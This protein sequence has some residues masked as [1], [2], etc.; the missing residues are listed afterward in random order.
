MN[1]DWDKEYEI[2]QSRA[3]KLPEEAQQA[4]WWSVVNYEELRHIC[5]ISEVTQQDLEEYYAFARE[6]KDYSL[7]ALLAIYEVVHK[8][9]TQYGGG[10]KPEDKGEASQGKSV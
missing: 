3:D 6:R 1:F 9:D 10:C 5:E 2:I 7:I 4:C 8:E